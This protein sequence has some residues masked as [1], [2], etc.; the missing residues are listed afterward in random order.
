MASP[1][2]AVAPSGGLAAVPEPGTLALLAERKMLL[3]EHQDI[4]RREVEQILTLRA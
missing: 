4:G 1:G 2:G 3:G